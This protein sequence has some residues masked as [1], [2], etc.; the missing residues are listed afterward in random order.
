VKNTE[1]EDLLASPTQGAEVVQ[2]EIVAQEVCI[3]IEEDSG[4]MP[5]TKDA[6]FQLLPTIFQSKFS[7]LKM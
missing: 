7:F 4:L 2:G 6:P 5:T 1:D 3:T